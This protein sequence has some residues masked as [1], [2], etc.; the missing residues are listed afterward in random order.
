MARTA[1]PAKKSMKK[2][3]TKKPSKDTEASERPKAQ[4]AST[5]RKRS[6][7]VKT[8]KIITLP[9]KK[10]SRPKKRIQVLKEIKFFQNSTDML[11]SKLPFSRLIRNTVRNISKDY[12][13]IRF[14]RTAILAFQEAFEA[15]IVSLLEDSN[16]CAL[17]AKRVTLY[18]K[19]I[20][21]VNALLKKE[22]K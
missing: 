19:D 7:A 10:T 15:Y 4:V 17:H 9:P 8:P 6:I 2:I 5:A 1:F 14:T 12:A 21:L 11:T 18:E 13:S 20:E 16:L 22:F 3:A